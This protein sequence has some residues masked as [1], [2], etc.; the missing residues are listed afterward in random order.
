[1]TSLEPCRRCG[2]ICQTCHVKRRSERGR[3]GVLR[4]GNSWW[5]AQR[6]LIW[7]GRQDGRGGCL[8]K[9]SITAAKVCLCV[10][11]C[12]PGGLL[13]LRVFVHLFSLMKFR[14]RVEHRIW[15]YYSY[16]NNI[17]SCVLQNY[18]MRFL[19]HLLTLAVCFQ[20]LFPF[21]FFSF[22][23]HID[24]TGLHLL[25][26]TPLYLNLKAPFPPVH[27]YYKTLLYFPQYQG[28]FWLQK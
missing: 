27:S 12:F 16:S 24:H 22:F 19:F 21:V 25:V 4:D 11:V 3:W 6:I 5:E 1:M 18:Q 23:F 26:Y 2:W 9:H 13:V 10:G 7:E 15:C 28:K 17:I 14:H 8:I 20:A